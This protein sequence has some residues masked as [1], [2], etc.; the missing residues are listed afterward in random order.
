MNEG[1]SK[2]SNDALCASM[3]P[4]YVI[5]NKILVCKIYPQYPMLIYIYPTVF[6]SDLEISKKFTFCA[7]VHTADNILNHLF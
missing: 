7:Y 6:S 3:P 1:G 2:L 4:T 5:N